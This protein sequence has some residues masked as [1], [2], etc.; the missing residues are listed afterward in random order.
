MAKKIFPSAPPLEEDALR[1]GVDVLIIPDEVLFRVLEVPVEGDA[2]GH[3]EIDRLVGEEEVP[4]HGRQVDE[5][6]EA[7]GENEDERDDAE[8]GFSVLHGP[9]CNSIIQA[10]NKGD[11][12]LGPGRRHG[13]RMCRERRRAAS[14]WRGGPAPSK[15]A[16]G[17]D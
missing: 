8:G 5:Q 1:A 9:L 12:R 13:R 7:Q 17:G 10:K 11:G 14:L 15:F 2:L 16:P 3:G 6:G 4:V